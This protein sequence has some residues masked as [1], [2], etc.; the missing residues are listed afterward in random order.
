MLRRSTR[1]ALLDPWTRRSAVPFAA[2]LFAAA[3]FAATLCA[4]GDAGGFGLAPPFGS[5]TAT[6][7]FEDTSAHALGEYAPATFEMKVIAAYIAEDV[8]E[9]WDNVGNTSMFYVNEDCRE[10]LMH[11]DISGGAA[12]DGAP[13]DKVVER[14][15]D[16]SPGADVNAAL[17]AQARPVAPGSYHYVRLEFCKWNHGGENNVRWGGTFGGD[18]V[19]DRELQRNTCTVDSGRMEPPLDI[20]DSDHVVVTLGYDLT[21]AVTASDTSEAVPPHGDD[22]AEING[23]RYCFTVPQFVP[24]VARAP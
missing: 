2:T 23:H 14:Y 5:A 16:F 20:A 9:H 24:R 8:D 19:D 18:R 12:E 21:S 4:C 11:C 15:F 13:I 22:C 1:C 10:D 17:N 7:R 6:L 3:L